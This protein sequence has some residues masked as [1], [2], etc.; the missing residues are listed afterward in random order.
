MIFRRQPVRLY[1]D[2]TEYRPFLR[3]DFHYR[4]AY[5]LTHEYFVG[6]EAGCTIDHHR[7]LRHHDGDVVGVP[8]QRDR[9]FHREPPEKGVRALVRVAADHRSERAGWCG[10]CCDDRTR[11]QQSAKRCWRAWSKPTQPS[12]SCID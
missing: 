4:C 9:E 8:V 3:Q 5:C 2:Y 11:S 1:R 6:G 7:P 12:G 10:G